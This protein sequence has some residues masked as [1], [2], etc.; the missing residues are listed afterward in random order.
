MNRLKTPNPRTTTGP[1]TTT[2][3]TPAPSTLSVVH[4][5]LLIVD[6]SQFNRFI[7]VFLINLALAFVIRAIV[8]FFYNYNFLYQFQTWIRIISSRKRRGWRPPPWTL[9]PSPS[10]ATGVHLR[11]II[12]FYNTATLFW[13]FFCTFILILNFYWYKIPQNLMLVI[14]VISR[15]NE[16]DKR[17]EETPRQLQKW[18]AST[19]NINENNMYNSFELN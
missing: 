9:T 15:W 11:I 4:L 7:S 2:N 3:P 14:G 6:L 8:G 5:R 10:P 13:A 19:P 1:T 12:F 16:A 18:Q 17:R